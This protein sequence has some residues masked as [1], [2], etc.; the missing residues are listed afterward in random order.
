VGTLGFQLSFQPSRRAWERRC[1]DEDLACESPCVSAALEAVGNLDRQPSRGLTLPGAALERRC[2][3]VRKTSVILAVVALALGL[4]AGAEAANTPTSG[5]RRDRHEGDASVRLLRL[6][7]V[8]PGD[9]RRNPG[10]Q[11]QPAEGSIR[12]H[13]RRG[14]TGADRLRHLLRVRRVFGFRRSAGE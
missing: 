5:R 8:L 12:L 2:W 14:D 1:A 6:N 4:S 10:R 3:P 13:V 11:R 9:L 7:R